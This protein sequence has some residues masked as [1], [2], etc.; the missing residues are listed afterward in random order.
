MKMKKL[1]MMKL[2]VGNAS[3]NSANEDDIN[4]GEGRVREPRIWMRDYVSGEELSE[5]ENVIDMAMV[6]STDPV[7]FE[8]AVKS[9]RWRMVM[10]SEI[11][12]IEKNQTWRL[13]SY[14][15]EPK[16]LQSNGS[17][18]LRSMSLDNWKNIK[19]VWWR[20]GTLNNMKWTTQRHLL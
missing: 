11:K 15:L 6:A 10:D 17:T 8:D 20:R 1:V 7:C 13:T 12:S 4:E 18:K 19:L 5:E 16:R 14:K 2:E 3:P 9:S